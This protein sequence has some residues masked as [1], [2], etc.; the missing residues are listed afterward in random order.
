MPQ[1]YGTNNRK[2][3]ELYTAKKWI[4]MPQKTRIL[5][6]LHRISISLYLK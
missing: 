1:K 4:K 5:Y 6:A 3:A 2:N